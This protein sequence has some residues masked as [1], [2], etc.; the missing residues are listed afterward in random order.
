[1]EI[2]G[3]STEGMSP[4]KAVDVLTGRPGTDVKLSV[5]HEGTETAETVNIRRAIIEVPSVLGDHR[6]ANDQWDFMID[7]DKKIGYVRIS[8]FIQN[9]ADELRKALDQLKEEG[10]KG[11]D[12]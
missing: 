9:T 2:D 3:T 6:G 11:S 10:V 12:P 8:S 4:D 7:K 5:L 1:M